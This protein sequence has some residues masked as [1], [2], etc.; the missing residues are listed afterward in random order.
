MLKVPTFQCSFDHQKTTRTRF[1]SKAEVP[2]WR[3]NTK[4]QGLIA[5]VRRPDSGL[6]A[7][8][9]WHELRGIEA[10]FDRMSR[11]YGQELVSRHYMT[12][13][14]FALVIDSELERVAGN[15]GKN[16]NAP[17][18]IRA[19]PALVKLIQSAGFVDPTP[20]EIERVRK[21]GLKPPETASELAIELARYGLCT[22]EDIA[23]ASLS[24]LCSVRFFEPG[25]AS[26]LRVAA[27]S[28]VAANTTSDAD[29]T[30][31]GITLGVLSGTVDLSAGEE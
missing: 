30:N 19:E 8:T 7:G 28:V 22:I 31:S 3:D 10:E 4:M 14:D 26:D 5:D 6:P 1:L 24:K 21:I 17:A 29:K 12:L 13:E 27:Q 15:R 18:E 20:D 9:Y 23:S 2:L 16:P 11:L 25:L